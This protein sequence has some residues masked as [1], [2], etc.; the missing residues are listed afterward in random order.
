MARWCERVVVR[1]HHEVLPCWAA[2]RS[3]RAHPFRVIS[4]DHHTDVLPAPVGPVAFTDPAAVVRAVRQLRHDQHFDC[5]VRNDFIG[6]AAIL[7]QVEPL[8]SIHPRLT[9]IRDPAWPEEQAILNAAPGVREL[10]DRVLEDDFLDRQLARATWAWREE[11]FWLDLDLDW[12]L[13]ARAA[14]PERAGRFRE[15][16]AR[17]VGITV[18][19][20]PEWVRLL[21]LPGETHTAAALLTELDRRFG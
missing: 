13:T 9:V 5:A 17:A 3:R 20:E 4:F 15:L 2:A 6:G 8:S 16:I 14:R 7:A 11:P 18:A 10:A 12:F 21:A 19:L 1:N